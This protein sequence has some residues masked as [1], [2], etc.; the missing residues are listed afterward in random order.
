[1]LKSKR[2]T[3]AVRARNS[4]TQ[5]DATRGFLSHIDRQIH[6]VWRA[7]NLLGFDTHLGEIAQAINP[8]AGL[9][10]FFTVVPSGLQLTEFAADNLVTRPVISSHIDA[11]HVD[12]SRRLSYQGECNAVGTAVNFSACF[13]TGKCISKIRKV[14]VEGFRR[15]RYITGVVGFA[16]LDGDQRLKLFV[17]CQIIA[18]QLDAGHHKTLAFCHIDGD[19]DV[20][21]VRRN[22]YLGRVDFEFEVTT[23]QIV[24]AQ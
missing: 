14:I 20:L 24:R 7:G 8:V 22:S 1:M 17:F 15:L 2:Q 12:P 21:F 19:I 23:R 10:N 11:T 13:G 9:T 3:Q 16:C 6:L 5:A 4:G 18:S